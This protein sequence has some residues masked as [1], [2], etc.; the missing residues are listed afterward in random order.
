MRATYAQPPLQPW[1][2]DTHSPVGPAG[3][4]WLDPSRQVWEYRDANGKAT[5]TLVA[6]IVA[7]MPRE[8]IWPSLCGI[9]ISGA[10]TEMPPI[11]LL[12]TQVL[13]DP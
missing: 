3:G 6:E 8:A 9:C 5:N 7:A 1:R 2:I 12:T 4:W 13:G 10:T 11:R